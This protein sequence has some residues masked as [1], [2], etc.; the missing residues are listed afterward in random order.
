VTDYI[1]IDPVLDRWAER[2]GFAWQREYKGY[3]VRSISWP[4]AGT[5]SIQIWVDP[6]ASGKAIVNV[7]RNSSLDSGR[8]TTKTAH[9][10]DTLETGLDQALATA[11]EWRA[12]AQA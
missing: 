9:S 5:E 2:Q 1:S 12:E 8:R 10:V 4:L 7:A 6:P 3:D 11:M